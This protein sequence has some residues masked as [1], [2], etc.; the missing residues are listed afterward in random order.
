MR[1]IEL[2]YPHSLVLEALP[3]TVCAIGFFDGVHKGHQML[4]ETAVAE[5][6][7]KRWRVQ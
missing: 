7:K 2:T 4:I 5:A 3:D 6:K 1:T